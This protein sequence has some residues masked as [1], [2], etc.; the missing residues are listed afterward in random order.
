MCIRDRSGTLTGESNASVWIGANPPAGSERS[1]AGNIGKLSV[2]RETLTVSEIHTLAQDHPEVE[3][4]TSPSA[5]PSS[6][7]S[8]SR[9][10][11][12]DGRTHSFDGID[13]FVDLG[14]FNITSDQVTF[15]V[16]IKASNFNNPPEGRI[17]S[18]ASGI[19]AQQHYFMLS[20]AYNLS[21]IHI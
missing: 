11:F 2:R 8:D 12:E 18:K 21:L 7:E 19:E 13:D 4:V 9:D 6:P 14:A 17:I 3:N 20:T 1:F 5:E 15:S 10:L 16:W